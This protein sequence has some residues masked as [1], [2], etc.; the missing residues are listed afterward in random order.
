MNIRLLHHV[1]LPV[2]DLERSKR[3]YRE[4]LGL[5]EIA[6]PNFP[7]RGAWFRLG[8]SQELHLIVN[9][10]IVP[11]DPTYREQK[12]VESGDIHLAVRVPNYREVVDFLRSQGYHEDGEA[13]DL[14]RLKLNPHSITGY[15][16]I[17]IIDPDRHVIEINADTL[18]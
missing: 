6:R 1:G 14:M 5:E 4:I 3:F 9:A 16:Q 17:Y 18:D 2:T 10:D 12:G 8:Q 11:S 7:F 15:P 13:R